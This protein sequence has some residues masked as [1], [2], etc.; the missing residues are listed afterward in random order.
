M[1]GKIMRYVKGMIFLASGYLLI[2]MILTM[3]KIF[4]EDA[5]LEMNA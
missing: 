2:S 5:L 1:T 3:Q 4:A